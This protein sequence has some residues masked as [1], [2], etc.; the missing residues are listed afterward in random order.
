MSSLVLSLFTPL[1]KIILPVFALIFAGYACRKT[2]R[3]GPNASS[4]LNRFVVYLAL[5]ALLF[6]IMATTPWHALDQPAFIAVFGL[7]AGGVFVL[8]VLI[9]LKQSRH[10]ADASLD[11]LNA[12]YPNAGF[13]G[14]PLCMLAFGH[15]SLAP[16]VIATIMTVCVLFAVAI[17]LIELGLQTEKKLVATLGKVVRS[18]VTNPLLFAPFAGWLCSGAGLT[19]SGGADTFLKLLGAAASPCALV[20]L[21]LFLAGKSE[22]GAAKTTTMLVLAKLTAQPLLTWWL[23]FHVFALP[24][25]WAKTAVILS[26]LPTGT[27]P[28]MLAEF[29]K[30]EAAVT[31]STILFSTVISL[32]T[33]TVCLAALS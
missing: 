14:L 30:R 16:A 6:D 2:N 18:L 13:I 31:S 4:E 26:A 8:T 17:V 19:I 3:L 32:I 23:A 12:A 29:Y 10:L 25:L 7:G 21:G 20:A 33:I 1:L 15:A 5:P 9:R 27:G 28:F 24:V 11:G 22:G